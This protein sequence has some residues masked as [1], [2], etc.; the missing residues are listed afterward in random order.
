MSDTSMKGVLS[1]LVFDNGKTGRKLDV[2]KIGADFEFDMD[3]CTGC[4]LCATV[5]FVDVLRWDEE[6]NVPVAAYPEDCAGCF[7]CEF[8]C[9]AHCIN[10]APRPWGPAFGDV[11]F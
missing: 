6:N 11:V 4:R 1:E 9:P 5:C 2:D 10:V 8:F 3:K 7:A